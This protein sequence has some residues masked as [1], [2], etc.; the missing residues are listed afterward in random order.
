MDTYNHATSYSNRVFFSSGIFLLTF[1]II[2]ISSIF[3]LWE[4]DTDVLLILVIITFLLEFLILTVISPSRQWSP[5]GLLFLGWTTPFLIA[6]LPLELVIFYI[7]QITYNAYFIFFVTLGSFYIAE[8][9]VLKFFS[10]L[11]LKEVQI[12]Q[13]TVHQAARYAPR[14]LIIIFCLISCAGYTIALI[15]S[16]GRIP[17]FAENV[18]IAANEFWAVPGSATLFMAARL[19]FLFLAVRVSW[20][21]IQG[22]KSG[23]FSEK[24]L[25]FLSLILI[26]LMF[27]YGKRSIFIYTFLPVVIFAIA[28]FRIK[29]KNIIIILFLTLILFILNAYIRAVYNFDLYWTGQDFHRLESTFTYSILQPFTYVRETFGNLSLVVDS[30]TWLSP[31]LLDDTAYEKQALLINRGKIVPLIATLSAS[32]GILPSIFIV[33]LIF[34]SYL[35]LY[36]LAKRGFWILIYC[37][38]SPGMALLWTS[39]LIDKQG[40]YRIILIMFLLGIS[41][42]VIFTRND[43]NQINSSR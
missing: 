26:L 7:P 42:N 10:Y 34:V 20:N 8:F 22:S 39:I 29:F 2:S 12:T 23:Y 41:F 25:L 21:A 37:I 32:Y 3:A 13:A 35:C 9:L 38:L 33:F 43:L 6:Q 30:S 4:V 27:S 31:Q 24:P 1:I 11:G 18:T 40:I 17:V 14:F 5:R 19:F 16:G 28:V 36:V 15:N